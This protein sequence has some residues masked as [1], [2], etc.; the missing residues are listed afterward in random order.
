MSFTE[1][2]L[3][4]LIELTLV[5]VDCVRSVT[6]SSLYDLSWTSTEAMASVSKSKV[7]LFQVDQ[8]QTAADEP[9]LGGITAVARVAPKVGVPY[10]IGSER[11]GGRW[12]TRQCIAL[13][14]G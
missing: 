3:N 6:G 5:V 11:A 8:I 13:L 10:T 14:T 12:T 2:A 9:K 7:D 1:Y 4:A